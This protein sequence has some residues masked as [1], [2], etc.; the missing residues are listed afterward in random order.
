MPAMLLFPRV[1]LLQL[2][3]HSSKIWSATGCTANVTA[4]TL[5]CNTV[6]RNYSSINETT[7]R[8]TLARTRALPGSFTCEMRPQL[9]N[10]PDN[11]NDVLDK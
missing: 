4:E 7:P 6:Y 11:Y 9:S 1:Q 8:V 5:V 10:W 2:L 3:D